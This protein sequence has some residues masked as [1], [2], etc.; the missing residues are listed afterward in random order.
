MKIAI[1]ADGRNIGE[2][3][4]TTFCKSGNTTGAVSSPDFNSKFTGVAA[5]KLLK[6]L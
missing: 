5:A 1:S 2:N 3:N 4:V 6:A